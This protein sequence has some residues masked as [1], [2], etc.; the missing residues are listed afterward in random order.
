[1]KII[2]IRNAVRKDGPI[3]YRRLYTGIAVV[4][5]ID[6]PVE[7]P[8]DFQI[9]HKPTGHIEITILSM[10]EVDYPIVPL[11]KELKTFIGSLDT[12]GKLPN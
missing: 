9:E 2:E 7:I 4:E 3:Y 11:K 12:A 10:G 5:L 8:L 1:M 6:K